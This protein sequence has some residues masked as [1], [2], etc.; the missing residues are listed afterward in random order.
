MRVRHLSLARRNESS[1]PE[2][3]PPRWAARAPGRGARRP[4][5][6][7]QSCAAI[8]EVNTALFSV[9]TVDKV[10]YCVETNGHPQVKFLRF[11]CYLVAEKMVDV[12]KGSKIHVNV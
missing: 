5:L 6:T 9:P 12:V 11:F 4:P 8:C 10:L 7:G 3:A 2:T 1:A